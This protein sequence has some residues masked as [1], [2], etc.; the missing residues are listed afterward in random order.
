MHEDQFKYKKNWTIAETIG[1]IG[2]I[3]AI[4]GIFVFRHDV[5]EAVKKVVSVITGGDK[6]D[7]VLIKPTYDEI[8]KW[9]LKI[10]EGVNH[11]MEGE[12]CQKELLERPD[13]SK[14]TI[15]EKKECFDLINRGLD[16]LEVIRSLKDPTNTL[17]SI[18]IN[19]IEHLLNFYIKHNKND[20]FTNKINILKQEKELLINK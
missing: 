20:M 13:L 10:K 17:Q 12:S 2:I 16:T 4:I 6:I 5:N 7:T 8:K 19:A 11:I 9:D 15:K 1:V 18:K 3:V 14:V